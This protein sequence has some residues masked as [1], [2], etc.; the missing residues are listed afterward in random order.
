MSDNVEYAVVDIETTGFSPKA[1]DRIVE[2]GVVRL[3]DRRNIVAEYDTLVNP[4]RDVGPTHLHGITAA[5]VLDAPTFQEVV[6][7]V[8]DLMRGAVFVAHNASFDLRFLTHECARCGVPMPPN[9]I[10]C[11]LK[12]SRMTWPDAPN[13]K[14]G[15]L[16]EFLKLD[17]GS[18]H[19]ALDDARSAAALLCACRGQQQRQACARCMQ[20]RLAPPDAWPEVHPSGK[21]HGRAAAGR[22]QRQSRGRLVRLFE[23]LPARNDTNYACDAYLQVL[24]RALQDRRISDDE[25]TALCEAAEALDMDQEEI[26]AAH[27]TFLGDLVRVAMLDQVMTE[28]E[29]RDIEEVAALLGV[30]AADYQAL[31]REALDT[32]PAELEVCPSAELVGKSVCF[33]G[34]FSFQ[35]DGKPITRQEL[36]NLA[37]NCGMTIRRNVT[38]KLDYLI[39]AD[40]ASMS[41]KARKARKYGTSIL[42]EPAFLAMIAQAKG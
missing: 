32:P 33:T 34:Q 21:R 37:A 9:A 2:I 20:G 36:E 27:R 3:D 28:T 8:I 23:R 25:L 18:Q 15:C 5:D 22:L 39:C 14:L 12:L 40:P 29:K 11:T 17:G 26:R 7:D 16:C 38:R 31:M 1:H 13:H 42:A 4:M 10:L 30:P 35:L 41:T 6:G 19:S 24:E